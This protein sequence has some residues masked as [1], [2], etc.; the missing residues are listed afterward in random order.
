[1]GIIYNP[2]TEKYLLTKRP[3]YAI[4]SKCVCFFWG[5]VDTH[6]NETLLKALQREILEETGLTM[7]IHEDAWTLQCVWES[8]YPTMEL[9]DI[10][11]KEHNQATGNDKMTD[12]RTRTYDLCA[13]RGTLTNAGPSISFFLTRE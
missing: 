12:R 3:S 5:N 2:L 1:M 4:I 13:S 10:M 11:R 9:M 6:K 7:G 8:V